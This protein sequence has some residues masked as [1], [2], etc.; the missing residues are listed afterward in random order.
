[1]KQIEMYEYGK[2]REQSGAI[3]DISDTQILVE[4]YVNAVNSGDRMIVSGAMKTAAPLRLPH[5]PGL[6]LAGIVRRT[7]RLVTSL[8]EGDRVVGLSPAGG[9]YADYA[10]LEESCAAAVPAGLALTGAVSLA[11]AGLSARQALFV[12]GGL[13]PGQRVLIEGAAGAVGHLA[14]QL[15]KQSGAYVIAVARP[16]QHE[17]LRGLGADRI[18]RYDE[19]TPDGSFEP[20]D[21]ALGM[22]REAA[23]S[24]PQPADG[25]NAALSSAQ[26]GPELQPQA[27]RLLKDGGTFVSLI[28]PS[29]ANVPSPRG[30]RALFARV[31]PNQSDWTALLSDA[32]EGRLR[33][34]TEAVFPFTADGIQ[35]AYRNSEHGKR[36]QFLIVRKNEE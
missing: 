35:E 16:A 14:V 7:G 30:I 21:L 6:E 22:I 33:L 25:P 26:P 32:S 2:L 9:G 10:V 36:G 4:V 19:E 1:M 31:L 12:F 20:A 17:F 13:R 8:R 28:S 5:V 27:Y 29:I 34:H 23:S 18:I 15:A 24:P 11:A 3:P